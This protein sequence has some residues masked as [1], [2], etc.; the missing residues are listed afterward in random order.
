MN[1]VL[2]ELFL[3]KCHPDRVA[4]HLKV[5]VPY[6]Q[7]PTVGSEVGRGAGKVEGGTGVGGGTGKKKKCTIS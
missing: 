1:A 3:R 6:L 7:A 5:A 2:F 4:E